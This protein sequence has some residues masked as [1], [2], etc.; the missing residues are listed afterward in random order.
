MESVKSN[1]ANANCTI[2]PAFWWSPPL[3]QAQLSGGFNM[4][5]S[6]APPGHAKRLPAAWVA[7]AASAP[8]ILTPT[9]RTAAEHL[10]DA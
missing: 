10:E 2:Y 1:A 8:L 9:C 5:A 4:A 7:A 3:R 6:L